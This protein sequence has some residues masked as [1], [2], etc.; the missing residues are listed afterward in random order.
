MYE[1]VFGERLGT[2]CKGVNKSMDSL[3]E[4]LPDVIP[5]TAL[6]REQ[7]NEKVIVKKSQSYVS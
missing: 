1:P 3:A 7:L 6:T 4:N 2:A 5:G